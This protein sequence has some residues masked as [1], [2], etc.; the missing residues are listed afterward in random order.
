V[1]GSAGVEEAGVGCVC[2]CGGGGLNHK[3][4]IFFLARV[5][6]V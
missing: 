3:L 5:L 6:C 4:H 2:V 1:W